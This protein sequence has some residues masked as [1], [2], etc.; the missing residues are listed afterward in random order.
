MRAATLV[1]TLSLCG[2]PLAAQQGD[3][4]VF[5]IQRGGRDGGDRMDLVRLNH[6][7]I[8]PAVAPH[9]ALAGALPGAVAAKAPGVERQSVFFGGTSESFRD[10]RSGLTSRNGVTVF[11][12]SEECS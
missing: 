2:L 5:A 9:A 12:N 1:L 3:R 6:D 10:A 11:G 7:G 8:V 4:G